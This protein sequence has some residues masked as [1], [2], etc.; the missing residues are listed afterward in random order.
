MTRTDLNALIDALTAADSRAALVAALKAAD[1][2]S[3]HSRD[4]K[5]ALTA[6]AAEVAAQLQAQLEAMAPA[7]PSKP[8]GP[9][10]PITGR[11]LS[12]R[13]QANGQALADAMAQG[14]AQADGSVVVP[15][16]TW[17][18]LTGKKD[19][20]QAPGWTAGDGQL[21]Q[22]ATWNP[23]Y[24]AALRAGVAVEWAGERNGTGTLTMV[25]LDAD[26]A[27]AARDHFAAMRDAYKAALAERKASRPEVSAS[28]VAA[29]AAKISAATVGKLAAAVAAAPK[30]ADGTIVLDG[31]AL[32]M[33]GL[34]ATWGRT[35]NS[36]L[37]DAEHVAARTL[38]VVGYTGRTAQGSL[39]LTPVA[40]QAQQEQAS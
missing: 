12:A 7:E 35:P 10:C 13:Q 26:A 4:G 18:A 19:G 29:R 28:V 40:A 22:P 39:V 31:E 30:T 2:Y 14:E 1:A 38:A 17:L 5:A 20:L 8:S 23:Y 3:G 21:R 37:K 32:A 24:L 6:H 9:A 36:H 11:K 25:Q 33:A 27:Q 16:A 15:A 34:G